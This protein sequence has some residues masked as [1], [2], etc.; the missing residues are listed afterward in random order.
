MKGR[1]PRTVTE[2]G[3]DRS[4]PLAAFR[5]TGAFVLLGDPG[6]GKTTE[7]EWEASSLGDD[8]ICLSARDF[9]ALAETRAAQ[10]SGKTLFIDGLDEVRAGTGDPRSSLDEI[11][12]RLDALGRPRFRLSCRAADWL[13]SDQER[14][15]MV[16]PGETVTVLRLDPL[17]DPDIEHLLEANL[18]D[19]EARRFLK[20]AR[21]KGL[22]GW[23][24]NPQGIEILIAAFTGGRGWPPNRRDAFEVACLRMA[25][26]RN[27]EHRDAAKDQPNPSEILDAAA[28]LCA[29][30]L[31]SGAAGCS[32]DASG[33]D[34]DYPALDRLGPTDRSL[35]RAA[36]DTK[37]FTE[38]APSGV[39]RFAPHHRQIAEFLG[40]RQLARRIESGLPVGRV[41]ALMAAP[42]GAPP[43]SL[44]GF[45][46]W[47]AAH[48]R[49]ARARL[50]D[51]DPVGVAAYGDL[52]GFSHTEKQRLL[53]KVRDQDPKLDAGRLPEDALRP[54]AVPELASVLRQILES[55]ERADADQVVSGFVLRALALGE[56]MPDLADLLLGIARDETRWSVANRRALDAF[57]HNCDDEEKSQEGA[58]RLLHD[59]RRGAVRDSDHQLLGTLLARMY[60]DEISPNDVWTYL[61]DQPHELLGRYSGFWLYDLLAKTPDE[62]F[63]E[64]LEAL[65]D[66]LP[67]LRTA[68]H[69]QA[70]DDLPLGLLART[71]NALGD[72]TPVPRLHDWLRIGAGYR[73]VYSNG[74]E[75][76]RAIRAF[77]EQRP[78]LHK[79]LW[80]EG[81][82]RCPEADD[83]PLYVRQVAESLYEARLPEDFG[84]FCLNQAVDLADARPRLAEW[85]LQ[86]T[87]GHAADERI[88]LEELTERTRWSGNLGDRLP[89]LL[90]TP[91]PR[92][93]LGLKR[94]ARDF[95]AQQSRREAQW[96][97]RVRSEV[98]ALRENRASPALLNSVARAYLLTLNQYVTGPGR[99]DWFSDGALVEAA[100]RGLRGVPFRPDVP[101]LGEILQQRPESASHYLAL[102]FLAGLEAME[103]EDPARLVA[104]DDSRWQIALALYYTVPTGR[105]EMPPWYREL[106]RSR[107]DL[108]AEVLVLCAKPEIAGGS[109][110]LVHLDCLVTDTDHANVASRASL[111]LL[112]GFP[113]R[114]R[115]TQLRVLDCLLWVA[116]RYADR[117]QLRRIIAKKVASKSVTA[118]QRVHWLAAGL[119]ASP[120]EYR[121][122]FDEF[123]R[124]RDEAT[125][126]AA[127][128]LCPDWG[129]SFPDRDT[130]PATLSLLIRRFGPM[131]GPDE[132]WKEGIV[133][134]PARAAARTRAF[135]HI[136]GG[137]PDTAAGEALDS[138]I[139][140]SALAAWKRTLEL[141]RDR[142]RTE[143]R[144]AG[145]AQAPLERVAES[146]RGGL[147]TN[148]ADL[149]ALVADHLDDLA[150]EIRGGDENAWRGFWNED[151]Y[152]RP[153]N[154]KPENS[155]RDVVMRELRARLHDRIAVLTEVRHA[156]NTRADL[157]VSY[158]GF[159]LPIEIKRE[160]HPDL[161]TA[162][163]E[164]LVPKYT[165]LPAAAGHGIYL[166]LWF[167]RHNIPKGPS[168]QPPTT[169]E[170]LHQ[171]L[172]ETVPRAHAPK[173]E[174][175]VLDVM[176]PIAGSGR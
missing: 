91:L 139:A 99:G 29:T 106:L 154:P 77:I 150:R 33:S 112:R 59:I 135:V 66:R 78:D 156:G 95:R 147:P 128:F 125:R 49:P 79:A 141:A 155:C 137:Q 101:D 114:S 111:S 167:G 160:G 70:L 46:A 61:L 57:F 37:L 108:V 132:E 62:R 48:C 85:L 102:P 86:R 22:S 121:V 32:L 113:V 170:E 50:I 65:S 69:A 118:A 25:G 43:T 109:D 129:V 142:Q 165:T 89:S 168:G 124:D 23:L 26:E 12:R 100:L 138:L 173:I 164:Q 16:S 21:E 161:W 55:D 9:L 90:Q 52:H 75:A 8:A 24:R 7:F 39:R 13:G 110:S 30:L 36:L 28:E 44:R 54:L 144:D 31:L 126:E 35:A 119:A 68:L 17:R 81:L 10:W 133:D 175:R 82:K 172:E 19:A 134:L 96:E 76:V 1:V 158:E 34:D 84:R 67:G 176:P 6:A 104:L 152:G 42:D 115:G 130:D 40:A 103:R 27:V 140:D 74:T 116:L 83:L 131:F 97:G 5:D 60:P 56:P 143:S 159:A 45:A 105:R 123:I 107:P 87:I 2:A 72:Q 4:Q 171:A 145:Y 15:R 80:L 117:T 92:G 11:R 94:D 41:F 98:R 93:Y 58:R 157:R 174:M 71:V 63:P 3:E 149:L 51:S 153:E 166:V 169:P 88:T 20:S 53:E 47:F 18:G 136:L 73:P 122:R 146:L 148:A 163:S 127:V 162:V 64:L 151:S 38:A 120:E 14:L